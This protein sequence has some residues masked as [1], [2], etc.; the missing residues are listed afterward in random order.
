M[1]A[2][3]NSLQWCVRFIMKKTNAHLAGENGQI[4]ANYVRDWAMIIDPGTSAESW[5][6]RIMCCATPGF[7]MKSI[8]LSTPCVGLPLSAPQAK[9]PS[10]LRF[11]GA[12][13]D[14]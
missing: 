10:S 12:L 5:Q 13:H 2:G 14:G 6:G 8:E 11:A 7:K 9:A 3:R 1:R 4:K